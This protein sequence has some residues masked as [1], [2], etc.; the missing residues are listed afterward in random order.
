VQADKAA[1]MPKGG[2]GPGGAGGGGPGGAGGGGP[3]GAGGGGPGG[4][5]DGASRV[6]KLVD[7][8]PVA[9]S[10]RAGVSDANYTEV[11]GGEIAEGD[12]LVTRDQSS[13]GGPAAQVRLRMF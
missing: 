6:Y 13:Q 7:G 12:K 9:V 11:L 3:G 1:A 5:R 4:R 2:G 10:V 8:K